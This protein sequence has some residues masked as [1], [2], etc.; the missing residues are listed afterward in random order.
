MLLDAELPERARARALAVFTRLAEAEARVHGMAV[1][2]VAF[3]EVGAVDSIVDI[4]SAALLLEQLGVDRLVVSALPVAGGTIRTAHGVTPL[5]AP[6]TLELLRG[7]PVVPG[8]PGREHV[9]PTG[10]AIAAA[11]A[12]P[13]PMPAMRLLGV[14]HGAGTRDPADVPNVVRVVLGEE[15]AP[16]SPEEVVVLEAQM[17]DLPGEHL[18]ALLEAL[19]AAGAL[20]AFAAQILMKKGRPGLLVQALATPSGSAAVE[21]ALLRHG[22]TFG[23]RRHTARRRVL[24]RRHVPV[25]TPWGEVRIKLGILD[26][27]LLRAAPEHEDVAALARAAGVPVPRVY[28]AAVRAFD[29]ED[30]P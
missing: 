26:G 8:P 25:T 22:S 12:E 7:W 23:V 18:P 27:E 28:A 3:H 19:L 6:A 1:E 10:A 30:R 15:S 24:D 9:T 4:V 16:S 21:L 20:D 17:D 13:G 11:L 14:G 5:P 29:A 2:D